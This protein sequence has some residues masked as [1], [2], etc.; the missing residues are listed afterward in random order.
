KILTL[1]EKTDAIVI[2]D[3]AYQQFSDIESF[4]PLVKKYERLVVFRTLSK[5]GL[6]ALRIGFMIASPELINEVNK[7]RLPFNI[8][9]LSQDL[10]LRILKD[11]VT[12]NS[13]IS[14]I[15]INRENLFSGLLKIKGVK[16]YPSDANFILFKVDNAEMIYKKLI[17]NDILVR[18]LNSH[19]EGCLRVTVGTRY[20]MDV[21]LEVL[22]KI[23]I[24]E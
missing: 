4:I 20:E 13:N 22:N 19:I 3:E 2:V 1:I 10:A 23:L 5:I 15:K 11:D 21:F 7:V 12:M 6:A 8:N 16:P 17:E 14:E 18:N 24:K 9:S